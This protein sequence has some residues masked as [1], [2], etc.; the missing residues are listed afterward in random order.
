MTNT[1]L[2]EIKCIAKVYIVQSLFQ[3][4][5]KKDDRPGVESSSKKTVSSYFINFKLSIKCRIQSGFEPMTS[6]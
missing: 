4:I 3:G 6:H 1:N 2:K 5:T